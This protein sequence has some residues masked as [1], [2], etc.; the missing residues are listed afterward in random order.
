MKKTG[1]ETRGRKGDDLDQSYEVQK[2]TTENRSHHRA[3][4]SEPE[5]LQTDPR[6]E[7]QVQ[8]FSWMYLEHLLRVIPLSR[9][10]P[11]LYRGGEE[12]RASSCLP[13][14]G[15]AAEEE[16]EEEEEEEAELKHSDE[17]VKL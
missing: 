17:L 2:I 11:Q 3:E 4:T 6:P 1:A 13:Y 10:N 16:E 9:S 8:T 15:S 5:R 7:V 12:R 14:Q